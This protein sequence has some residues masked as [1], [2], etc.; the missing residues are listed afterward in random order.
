MV[1][2]GKTGECGSRVSGLTRPT[3]AGSSGESSSLEIW[4]DPI[5]AAAKTLAAEISQGRAEAKCQGKCPSS[6]EKGAHQGHR[7]DGE[8]GGEEVIGSR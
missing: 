5:K 8:L 1:Q 7:D 6:G 2:S 4:G 3:D